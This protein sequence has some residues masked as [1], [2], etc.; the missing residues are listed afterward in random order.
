MSSYLGHLC[1][2]EGWGAGN[3]QD[4]TSKKTSHGL[5]ARCLPGSLLDLYINHLFSS[6]QHKEGI[7]ICPFYGRGK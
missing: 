4:A 2:G 6:F 7:V 1:V 3:S 5:G